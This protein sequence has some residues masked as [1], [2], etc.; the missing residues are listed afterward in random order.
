MESEIDLEQSGRAGTLS[1][2]C[3][4]QITFWAITAILMSLGTTCFADAR[5]QT[6]TTGP[7]ELIRQT[8]EQL[9]DALHRGSENTLD[10]RKRALELVDKI[11]SP[12]VDFN[13]ISRWTLGKQWRQASEAQ[14][15]RF[16]SEF[17]TL[18][19]RAYGS[20]V[21]THVGA[22][23][24]YLP[25]RLENNPSKVIVQTRIPQGGGGPLE[26]DY[27]LHRKDGRWKIYDV[28]VGGVSLVSTYRT[29]F[30]EQVKR[31]GLDGLIAELAARNRQ[32]TDT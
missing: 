22:K 5:G 20:A 2:P 7:G 23:L 11:V 19:L 15:Q 17:R 1:R 8:T 25:V 10:D 28:V 26:I 13:R 32:N 4:L 30:A 14:R 24:S 31:V 16:A 21:T 9:L 6:D 18:L 12:H 3:T 27:R 29:S